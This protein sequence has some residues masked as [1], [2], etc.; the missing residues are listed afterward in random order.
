MQWSRYCLWL[1]VWLDFHCFAWFKA[2]V[3]VIILHVCVCLLFYSPGLCAV[4]ILCVC[5]LLLSRFPCSFC[6][7]LSC[8][9]LVAGVWCGCLILPVR[10]W[11]WLLLSSFAT[12]QKKSVIYAVTIYKNVNYNIIN[13]LIILAFYTRNPQ[14]MYILNHACKNL[15]SFTWFETT[16]CISCKYLRKRFFISC[17]YLR[18]RFLFFCTYLW[19]CRVGTVQKVFPT[20]EDLDIFSQLEKERTR[21]PESLKKAN[22]HDRDSSRKRMIQRLEPNQLLYLCCWCQPLFTAGFYTHA[23]M[24]IMYTTIVNKNWC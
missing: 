22:W 3:L 5:L 16:V 13:V 17:I 9:C 14:Y 18:K 19:R 23:H 20:F 6:C 10:D 12:L 7:I 11:L 8:I 1:C 15:Q 2:P 21:K 4:M 24:H